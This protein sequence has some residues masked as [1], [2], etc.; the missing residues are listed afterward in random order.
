MNCG[1]MV[2]STLLRTPMPGTTPR[3]SVIRPAVR[4]RSPPETSSLPGTVFL[5]NIGE[6]VPGMLL[7]VDAT[8]Q[9]GQRLR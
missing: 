4:I 9:M 5:Q 7:H 6:F 8:R 1:G 2:Q 3:Y